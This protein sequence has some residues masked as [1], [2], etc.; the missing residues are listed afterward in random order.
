M[1]LISANHVRSYVCGMGYKVR[2]DKVRNIFRT[3]PK[4]LWNDCF[5]L[6]QWNS[7]I[8]N[9]IVNDHSVITSRILSQNGYLSAQINPVI[10]NSSFNE[11]E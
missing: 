3:K 2:N 8:T 10:T 5:Y 4:K 7:A 6:M 9:S 11:Q 1:Q